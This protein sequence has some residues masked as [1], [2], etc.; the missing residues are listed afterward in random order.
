MSGWMRL[1]NGLTGP[2]AAIK[3]IGTRRQAQLLAALSLGTIVL[4]L[5]AIFA[6]FLVRGELTTA[7]LSLLPIVAAGL[8]SYILSRSPLFRVGAWLITI[9]VSASAYGQIL[10]GADIVNSF[11][12]NI[13]MGLLVGSAILSFPAMVILTLVNTLAI[14]IILPY[15]QPGIGMSI[16]GQSMGSVITLGGLLLVVVAFRNSIERQRLDEVQ[17]MNEE[18]NDTR[19]NL[20]KR[21]EDRTSELTQTSDEAK[22]RTS[23]LEAIS[24]VSRAIAQLQDIN[25]LLPTVT[26]VI[27]EHLGFYHVAIFLLDE[28][29]EYAVLRAANSTGG[30]RMLAR[31]HRLE[32]GQVGIVGYVAEQAQ[33]RISLD[34]GSDAIFFDNPDLPDTHS[35]MALPLKVGNDVIG[36]LDVQSENVEAFVIQD[37]EVMNILADQVAIAIENSRRFTATNRALEEARAFYSEYLRQSWQPGA[38]GAK[39]IGYQYKNTVVI[40]LTEPTERPEIHSAVKSGK[41]VILSEKNPAY[42]IPL[43]L[44]GE[45]IGVLDIRSSRP[46]YQWT[47]NERALIEAVVERA[48]LAIENARLFEE[49]TRR[50]DR[51]RTVSEITTTIRSTTE[52]DEMLHIALDELKK[53]LGA[54]DIRVRPYSLQTDQRPTTDA[55][56]NP[57]EM[58]NPL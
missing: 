22:K 51:E 20:E 18:L 34:V 40:P 38:S 17:V 25:Q 35:E 16:I 29:K 26:Q 52:P 58:P 19:A 37:L 44:R 53:V 9:A 33:P 30:Q 39:A 28:N 21:V 48:T 27:S 23:Q 2:H 55:E 43:K 46:S 8:L 57:N 50:A 49:T 13:G 5:I 54:S 42:A 11:T 47:D 14:P 36:V 32:V 7:S 24:E 31:G 4:F 15:I 10:G 6:T 41:P 3:E 12:Q 45:V 1:W 56:T